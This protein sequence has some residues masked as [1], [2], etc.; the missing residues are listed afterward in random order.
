VP[1]WNNRLSGKA[2]SIYPPAGTSL[3]KV[4]RKEYSIGEKVNTLA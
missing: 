2:I 4:I 1:E 3:K